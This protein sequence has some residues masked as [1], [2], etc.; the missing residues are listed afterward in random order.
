MWLNATEFG[1]FQERGVLME[2][3]TSP[4]QWMVSPIDDVLGCPASK[5]RTKPVTLAGTKGAV[6]GATLTGYPSHGK[7]SGHLG[8]G[9]HSASTD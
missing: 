5:R 3:G 7:N 9:C 6:L 8:S 4:R 1:V 2:V